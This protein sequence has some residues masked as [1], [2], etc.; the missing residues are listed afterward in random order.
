MGMNKRLKHFFIRQDGVAYLEFAIALPLLVALFMG[1]VE[2]TRY[3]LIV[4]KIEKAAVTLSDVVSQSQT[5]TTPQLAQLIDAAK[6][7]VKPYSFNSNGYVI[8]SS[9]TK[10]GVAAPKVNWQYSG[11]GTWVKTSAVGTTGQTALWVPFTLDDKENIIVTEVFYNFTPIIA[12][13]ILSSQTV[14]KVSTFRPRLGALNSLG[15]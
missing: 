7:V 5:I 4:Q 10:T 6:Q 8:I 1:G 14:Y 11:G 9:I 13:G 2:L 3:I 12:N 15:G